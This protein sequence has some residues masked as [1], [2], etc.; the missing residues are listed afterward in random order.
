MRSAGAKAR[1]APL[2][3]Q[4]AKDCMDTT[5]TWLARTAKDASFDRRDIVAATCRAAGRELQGEAKRSPHVMFS[6]QDD[7]GLPE[8]HGEDGQGTEQIDLPL[9]AWALGCTALSTRRY[10]LEHDD[11]ERCIKAATPKSDNSES[12]S[13]PGVRRSPGLHCMRRP[14]PRLGMRCALTGAWG[15]GHRLAER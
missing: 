15:V 5:L 14:E 12:H 4:V 3:R 11:D 9:T 10:H 8:G 1:P 2:L 6:Q 13:M 7:V